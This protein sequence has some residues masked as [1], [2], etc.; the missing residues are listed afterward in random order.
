MKKFLPISIMFLALIAFTIPAL[1]VDHTNTPATIGSNLIQ[2]APNYYGA[3]ISGYAFQPAEQTLFYKTVFLPAEFAQMLS[4]KKKEVMVR[5]SVPGV[6]EDGRCDYIT[7]YMKK[8]TLAQA[9]LEARKRGANTIHIMAEG[10]QRTPS[11]F[12]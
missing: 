8:P 1:A 10:A 6:A 11:S 7:I 2:M 3:T 12:G 4:D 9:M 5:A